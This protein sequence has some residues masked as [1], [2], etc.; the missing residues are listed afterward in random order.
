MRCAGPNSAR[1]RFW[2]DPTRATQNADLGHLVQADFDLALIV[3]GSGKG[4]VSMDEGRQ[5]A[6][7]RLVKATFDARGG[8]DKPVPFTVTTT[9]EGERAEAMRNTLATTSFE[10]MQKSYLNFYA[11]YYSGLQI[12]EPMQVKDDERNNR[13]ITIEHYRIP[14][15][16]NWSDETKQHTRISRRRISMKSCA[17]RNRQ[18]APPRS[19]SHAQRPDPDHGSLLPDTWTIKRTG[20]GGG[21]AFSFERAIS[22]RGNRLVITDDSLRWRMK[23][24]LPTPRATPTRLA[25][26]RSGQIPSLLGPGGRG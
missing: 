17:V 23:S 4:L 20:H 7:A 25:E 10:E 19:A 14:E 9:L 22:P 12:A 11:G 21:S 26:A 8:L 1:A 15:F 13:I 18:S 6:P 24:P 5:S 3:D 16:S 2:L